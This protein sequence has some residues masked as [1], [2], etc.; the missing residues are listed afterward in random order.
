MNYCRIDRQIPGVTL[1]KFPDIDTTEPEMAW[2]N[3]EDQQT[4]FNNYVDEL[5][6]P[7]MAFLMIYG[8]RP[9]EA[10]ALK[11][12]DMD[13]SND[14]F[15]ISS[16]FS[17]NIYREKKRK[18]RKSKPTIKPIVDEIRDHM[19]ERVQ[20]NLP[21]AWVFPNPRTGN[22]YGQNTLHRK[23]QRIKEERKP[24]GQAEVIWRHTA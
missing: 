4:I 3:M 24:T 6:K 19:I 1:P 14:C 23:W 15:T 2:L 17:G 21:E 5:D 7:I 10:R 8:C 9:C 18:G 16:S 11:C 22:A 12:K 20:G 13:L